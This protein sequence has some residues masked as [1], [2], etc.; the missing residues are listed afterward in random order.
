MD[1][2]FQL[3]ESFKKGDDKS[4]EQLVTKHKSR[5]FNIVYSITGNRHE[6]D[7][8]AQ[9]VFLKVYLS[10]GSFKHKSSFST[11]LYRIT[12][13]KCLDSLKRNKPVSLESELNYEESLKLKDVLDSR[14]ESPEDKMIKKEG[15]EIIQKIL[16]SLPQKYRVAWTL[17]EIENF[18]YTEISQIMNISIN[19]VKVWLYRAR[20]K[21]KEKLLLRTGEEL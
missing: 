17:R 20:L 8:I 16:N 21:L 7:E 13:N 19:K 15:Q 12:V 10:A 5:V 11:W 2:D 9:E 3:L 4:F 18:T 1:E 14:E 6:A